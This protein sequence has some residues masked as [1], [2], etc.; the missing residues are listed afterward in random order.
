MNSLR[1]RIIK[2]VSIIRLDNILL[3]LIFNLFPDLCIHDVRIEI[4]NKKG[5]YEISICFL[6][7][8]NTYHIAVGRNGIYIKAVN[9]LFDKHINFY[10]DNIPLT[11]KCK[12]VD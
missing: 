5:E 12:A 7:D 8:L 2:K 9:K 6:K 10:K 4:N 1:Y 11:I 3:N